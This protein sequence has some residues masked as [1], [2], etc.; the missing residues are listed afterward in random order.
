[1]RPCSSLLG[2]TERPPSIPGLS[3]A[4]PRV[5]YALGR[6]PSFFPVPFCPN[7]PALFLIRR[8][9]SL[10]QSLLLI[11]SH[12]TTP[13]LTLSLSAG[14]GILRVPLSATNLPFFF[15]TTEHGTLF[16]LLYFRANQRRPG[17]TFQLLLT[18]VVFFQIPASLSCS[19]HLLS[20]RFQSEQTPLV[21]ATHPVGLHFPPR[22]SLSAHPL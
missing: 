1:M 19:D 3:Q 2:G 9:S 13:T 16:P 20:F 7:D 17:E 14:N 12:V 6:D 10:L 8:W 18:R 5:Q 22:V 4:A 21:V 11:P 15:S